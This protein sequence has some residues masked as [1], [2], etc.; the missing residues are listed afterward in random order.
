M[1]GPNGNGEA[2]SGSGTPPP[3]YGGTM[4]HDTSAPAGGIETGAVVNEGQIADLEI[5]PIYD[6]IVTN[7]QFRTGV[8]GLETNQMKII[9]YTILGYFVY[10]RFIK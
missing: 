2:S 1:A 9:L 4:I 10:T 6:E 7:F 5:N 8:L 3:E